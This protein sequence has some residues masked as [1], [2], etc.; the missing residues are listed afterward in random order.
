LVLLYA[1]DLITLNN[2]DFV[3]GMIREIHLDAPM[4]ELRNI[5]IPSGI[6]VKGYAG[7]SANN[8]Y[9]WSS[10]E[11]D[12]NSQPYLQFE[13]ANLKFSGSATNVGDVIL[14]KITH[15]NIEGGTTELT[16][17]HFNKSLYTGS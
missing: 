13:R 6:L 12:S 1:N 14:E 2:V 17:G 4:I 15:G 16:E 3:G 9:N 7:G 5:A 8:S 10:K 11:L